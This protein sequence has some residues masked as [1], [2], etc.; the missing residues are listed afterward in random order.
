M[1]NAFLARSRLRRVEA[2]V[3]KLHGLQKRN[4]KQIQ[5]LLQQR[6]EL[7]REKYEEK[8]AKLEAAKHDIIAKVKV[9]EDQQRALEAQLGE[10]VKA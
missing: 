7:E 8:K 4:R 5:R 2:R 3:K 1:L 6:D 9:L 10:K